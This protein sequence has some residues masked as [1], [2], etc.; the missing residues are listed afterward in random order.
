MAPGSHWQVSL[1]LSLSPQLSSPPEPVVREPS[2][3]L[4]QGRAG[5]LGGEWR[6]LGSHLSYSPWRKL[7]HFGSYG[8]GTVPKKGSLRGFEGKRPQDGKGSGRLGERDGKITG[9]PRGG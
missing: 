9:L 3:S 2:V 5:L 7:K 8:E 6:L 1:P 4:P